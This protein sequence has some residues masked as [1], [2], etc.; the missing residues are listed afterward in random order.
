MSRLVAITGATGFA[1]RHAISELQGRGYRL[2]ALVRDPQSAKLPDTIEQVRG[3]LH[4]ADA[5]SRLMRGAD[6]AVHLAGATSALSARDYFRVNADGTIAV[7]NA[8]IA[9]G[10]TRFVHISSLSAREPRLSPYGAS[11]RAGED[12]VAGLADRLNA[13]IIRPP[14]VYGPG[15]KGTLPLIKELTRPIA[16]IP[17]RPDARFSLIHGRDLARIIADTLE[18]Q[19]TGIHEVSDG[20]A[21]GYSWTDLV[22]IAAEVRGGAIRAVFLPRAVPYGVALAA[23]GWTRV[24]GKPGMVNRGKVRELYH[25]DWVSRDGALRLPNP[26]SFAE[27]LSETVSWYRQAG[28]LPQLRHADRTGRNP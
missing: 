3:G 14:A 24:T 16:V 26:V 1:G 20:R 13:V 6:A 7:A 5:L 12:A 9:E 22:A 8:A 25:P 21:G 4:D 27:G 19:E 17:G 28:W 10:V 2:R 15:D 11:K 23:E 18:N